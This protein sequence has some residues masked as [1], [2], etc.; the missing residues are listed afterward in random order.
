MAQAHA[1]LRR[2]RRTLFRLS[3]D[4][5]D[6]GRGRFKSQSAK[7]AIS[8]PRI[9]TLSGGP[10]KPAG[11]TRQ[12]SSPHFICFR[13]GG[14]ATRREEEVGAARCDREGRFRARRLVEKT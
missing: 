8:T 1:P 7:R 9:N 10:Q 14:V 3:T 11:L 4:C 12:G 13:I 2:K 5:H 6:T